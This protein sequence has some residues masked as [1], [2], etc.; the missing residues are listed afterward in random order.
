MP[1]SLPGELGFQS[2]FC[3]PRTMVQ[4]V[5]TSNRKWISCV[6]AWAWQ[7]GTVLSLI[8]G[9]PFYKEMMNTI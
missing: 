3:P 7:R 8:L 1:L 4:F 6:L 2:L 9:T 5:Y